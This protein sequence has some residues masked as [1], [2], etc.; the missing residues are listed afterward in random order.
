VTAIEQ[1]TKPIMKIN[2]L[3]EILSRRSFTQYKLFLTCLSERNPHDVVNALDM[4]GVMTSVDIIL[5][6][7]NSQ[8]RE[9][10][11]KQTVKLFRQRVNVTR[12]DKTLD[13]LLGIHDV[14]LAGL[15]YTDSHNVCACVICETLEALH[16]LRQLF[17]SGLLKN[18]IETVFNYFSV[19]I[20]SLFQAVREK[21][22]SLCEH[23]KAEDNFHK[24]SQHAEQSSPCCFQLT[25]LWNELEQIVLKTFLILYA[26]VRKTTC[27]PEQIVFSTLT[28]V[29]AAWRMLFT[30]N[31]RLIRSLFRELDMLPSRVRL[32]KQ[33]GVTGGITGV[34]HLDGRIFILLDVQH[35]FSNDQVNL[36]LDIINTIHV[37]DAKT[38]LQLDDLIV[39]I[40]EM[41]YFE[42]TDI[43]GCNRNHCLYLNDYIGNCILRVSADSNNVA[44][45]LNLSPCS[46]HWK[47]SKCHPNKLSVTPRGHVLIIEKLSMKLTFYGPDAIPRWTIKLPDE[48]SDDCYAA[49]TPTGNYVLSNGVGCRA[50]SRVCEV[51]TDGRVIRSYQ[52][53]ESAVA[54]SRYR[55]NC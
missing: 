30:S 47:I 3:I 28:S 50:H 52:S 12:S 31:Q 17:D 34:T 1:L 43:D 11:Q 13:E 26:N 18:N 15:A 48:M 44:R 16:T 25:S 36:S 27:Q 39:T 22:I 55:L 10:L 20:G 8:C 5:G 38:F 6:G 42:F 53:R 51:T 45:W 14:K 7:P 2:M 35:K 32:V 9:E 40:P 49:K 41:G 33:L 54:L 19:I 37:Y 24:V 29:C 21:Y 46:N 23:S 4:N